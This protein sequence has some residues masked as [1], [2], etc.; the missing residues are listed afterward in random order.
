MI[1][2]TPEGIYHAMKEYYTYGQRQR[3]V[4]IYEVHTKGEAKYPWETD[5]NYT[6][7]LVRD[8]RGRDTEFGD[9][10]TW[11]I[12]LDYKARLPGIKAQGG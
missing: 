3:K 6:T 1:I 12:F 11:D 8:T 9:N 4:L 5:K 10:Y 7:P 2:S